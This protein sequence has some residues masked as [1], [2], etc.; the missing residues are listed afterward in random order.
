MLRN[1]LIYACYLK[2]KKYISSSFQIFQPTLVEKLRNANARLIHNAVNN[3]TWLNHCRFKI[4]E[5]LS[6]RVLQLFWNWRIH[7][8]ISIPAVNSRNITTLDG[9]IMIRKYF[10]SL[11]RANQVVRDRS[12]KTFA[13]KR[14]SFC[15][16]CLYF[17]SLSCLCGHTII[18]KNLKSS[19]TK[20]STVRIWTTTPFLHF[21]SGQNLRNEKFICP[22]LNNYSLSPLPQWT[23]PLSSQ[24]SG[25]V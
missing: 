1:H 20:S 3:D 9:L 13:Q 19:A 10:P 14:P 4:N 24:N 11:S 2:M 12:W 8:K 16:H 23:K 22:H 17:S 5:L 6:L 25:R 18:F 7:W 15:P 21:R